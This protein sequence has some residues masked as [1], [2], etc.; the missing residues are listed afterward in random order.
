MTNI[1]IVI[2]ANFG[3]EGKGLMTDYFCFQAREREE[4]CIVVCSNGGSQRGHTVTTPY[5]RKHVFKHF[6]SGGLAE[7]DTYLCKHFIVNPIQFREEYEELTHLNYGIEPKVYVHKDC[8]WTTPM[9][10]ILNQIIEESRGEDRHGSCGMGIWETIV[11]HREK[12]IQWN[13]RV[14][15]LISKR[16]WLVGIAKHYILYRLNEMAISMVDDVSDEWKEI[17]D[18]LME[19]IID[20]YLEDCQFFVDH[21]QF[22]DDDTFLKDYQNIVFENGQGL[23]LDQNIQGY[24]E[25]TTPSNTGIQNAANIIKTVFNE[26]EIDVEACYVTRTYMTRHGA[27]RFDS[28]CNKSEI[29]SDMFDETNVPNPHQ[30]TLR[31]GR[32]DKFGLADRITEDFKSNYNANWKKSLAVTHI[33]EYPFTWNHI[34]DVFNLYLS[35]GMTRTSVKIWK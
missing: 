22:V 3:D 33:N 14:Y 26:D 31:Y 20:H 11:R 18:S 23:L 27:G 10:M 4:S 28:E 13:K 16:F 21:V 19:D 25:H 8:M 17:L 24:G 29:N 6:G 30:G 34:P 9:D 12:Y 1:K 35:D 15:D 2:G 5:E 32:L 7:A